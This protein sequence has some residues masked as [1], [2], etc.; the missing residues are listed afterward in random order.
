MKIVSIKGGLGNQIFQYLFYLN[1]KSKDDKV[2]LYLET[3]GLNQHNGWEL[4]KW[5]KLGNLKFSF[6]VKFYVFLLKIM[7]KLKIIPKIN[8]TNFTSKGYLYD[9]YWQDLKYFEN[10]IGGLEFK[11]FCL[12]DLNQQILKKMMS[13]ESVSIHIRRGD[14]LNEKYFPI[15]GNICTKEYYQKAISIINEYVNKPVYFVFSND[16]E[17]VKNNFKGVNFIY[18]DWNHSENSFFDL[19]LMKHCKHHII[20][21]SSFSYWGA[22]FSQN[23]NGL[24]IY[25]KKWYNS[26]YSPPQIFPEKW[27]GI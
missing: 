20:A 3:K 12:S 19:Y 27:I 8:E 25:P 16:I 13:S 14:Y 23:I 11:E 7:H 21:N 9:G 22:M 4:Y 26:M 18:V 1:L 24:N 17:W 10:Y 6:W 2:Y 15:Y 5:F